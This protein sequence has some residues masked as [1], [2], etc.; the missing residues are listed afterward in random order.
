MNLSALVSRSVVFFQLISF[1]I[2]AAAQAQSAPLSYS[3]LKTYLSP[4][5][6]YSQ[7]MRF[8]AASPPMNSIYQSNGFMSLVER[9]FAEQT[10]IIPAPVGEPP[11]NTSDRLAVLEIDAPT[12][13]DSFNRKFS[14]SES[15]SMRGV[16]YYAERTVYRTVFK[17]G[18]TISTTVYPVYDYP[19]TVVRINIEKAD[20]RLRVV[21]GVRGT[22]FQAIS[23]YDND[24]GAFGSQRWPYRLLV[25]TSPKAELRTGEVRWEVKQGDQV[26]AIIALG[27]NYKQASKTIRRVM[28]SSDLMDRFTRRAWNRYL[29]SCPIVVPAAD[30]T[31]TIGTTGEQ[32]AIARD[33]LVRS[34][35]WFWR[36]LL[37]TSCRVNYLRACPMPIADWSKFMG[38][39]GNDGVAETMALSA[40]SRSDLA[41]AAILNWFR[42]AV[43]AHGDG[44]CP[45][46]LFPSGRNTYQ[47]KGKENQ[48][49][50]VPQQGMLVGTYVRLTGDTSILDERPGGVAKA[51]TLWQTLVAYQR[52]LRN[53]R[54]FNGDYLIDWLHTY[55]TGWDDKDSPFVDLKGV[56]T[57]AINEQV[58]NLWSLQEMVYLSRLRG[59]DASEWHREIEAVKNAVRTKLWDPPTE[60]YWD[61]NARDNTLWTSGENLDAYY[62]LYYE[63]DKKRIAAMMKRL[64]DPKKFNGVLLPTLAFDDEKWGGY[65]RG[66]AWP[67]IFS[68]LSVALSRAGERKLAFEWLA[69]AINSNLGPVLPE[70]VDPAAYPPNEHIKG[71]VRIMGYDALDCLAFPD[72]TGLRMWSGDDLVVAPDPAV[73]KVF[74]RGQKW[75]GE[76]YNAL[77]DPGKPTRIWRNGREMK[78]LSG[79]GP[80]R[81]KK[82]GRTVSFELGH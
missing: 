28:Q 12:F 75:M 53:V 7:F 30:V 43:N 70:S 79:T 15:E 26:S 72:V 66:P 10:L 67:R 24:V 78:S 58:Y 23:A 34:Q 27:G 76:S 64:S 8:E 52:N 82:M 74:V 51:R 19:A 73:G 61:L 55:E 21:L 6:D 18:P 22:G 45:W 2:N 38:M 56:P 80:W 35:L 47:A 17:D 33:D 50:S 60:R 62:F 3:S 48:T 63:P 5:F 59:E 57:S 46:T 9:G 69:R 25:G 54:D 37:N 11:H 41:R 40:T 13:I 16:E 32:K 29:D 49:E 77:F 36:G 71:G 20:G 44:T 4:H 1:P 14:V 31:F 42:Y 81:A 39:W 68:Y 65:W